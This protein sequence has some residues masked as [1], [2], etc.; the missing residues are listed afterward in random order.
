LYPDLV[1]KAISAFSNISRYNDAV[2]FVE[3][4]VED[5]WMNLEVAEAWFRASGHVH[6]DYGRGMIENSAF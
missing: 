2:E 5:L 3:Y 6:A 4:V 1:A